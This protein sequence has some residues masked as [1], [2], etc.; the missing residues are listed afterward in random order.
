M[1]LKSFHSQQANF[2]S[3]LK[4]SFLVLEIRDRDFMFLNAFDECPRFTNG[5][6]NLLHKI[7]N[8]IPDFSKKT[9]HSWPT[10]ASITW[11]L[12]YYPGFSGELVTNIIDLLHLM[13]F[14]FVGIHV[15]K[16][17]GITKK[18]RREIWKTC[19]EVD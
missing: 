8:I 2:Y 7:K 19:R 3:T 4:K 12:Y 5:R 6:Q 15:S 1:I 14:F 9:D 11:I 10:I 16:G 13:L 18:R 17:H